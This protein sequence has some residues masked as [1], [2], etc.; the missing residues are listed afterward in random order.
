VG[1]V[2]APHNIKTIEKVK[3][4]GIGKNIVSAAYRF[5]AAKILK[6]RLCFYGIA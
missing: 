2:I 6:S 5:I 1:G 4:K 3:S